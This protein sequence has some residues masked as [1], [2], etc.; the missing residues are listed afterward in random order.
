M[1]REEL[2]GEMFGSKKPRGRKRKA[3]DHAPTTTTTTSAK[4]DV[5]DESLYDDND[6]TGEPSASVGSVLSRSR[7]SSATAAKDRVPS[8]DSTSHA[9]M[10][11]R[12]HDAYAT[13]VF[14]GAASIILSDSDEDDL[15]LEHLHSSDPTA[16]AGLSAFPDPM[17]ALPPAVIE[18]L[19]LARSA[20]ALTRSST[21][22]SLASCTR[23]YV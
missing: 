7:G 23:A 2:M 20:I 22:P 1:S 9:L 15:D 16:H 6:D 10:H 14:C 12:T 8:F 4:R 13:L 18:S 5:D 17:A 11:T 19:R 21:T 3:D